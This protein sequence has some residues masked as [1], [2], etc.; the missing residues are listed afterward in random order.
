M[1]KTIISHSMYLTCNKLCYL[2]GVVVS[3]LT[4]IWILIS[5]TN[6]WGIPILKQLNWVNFLVTQIFCFLC[7][8]FIHINLFIFLKLTWHCLL[9]TGQRTNCRRCMRACV[10]SHLSYLI[11]CDPMDC[12]L[13]GSSVH[14][15]LQARILEWVAMPSS[16]GS[17]QPSV[18]PWS[19]ASPAL[20]D[21]FFTFITPWQL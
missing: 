12:S 3:L 15:I 16:K 5:V 9:G 6:H 21:G 2:F 20:A 19:L 10:L 13:P 11:L 8:C 18:K 14:G 1:C 4:W 7:W 17:S